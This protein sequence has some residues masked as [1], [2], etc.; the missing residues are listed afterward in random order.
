MLAFRSF[1]DLTV[2]TR[3]VLA[4][5]IP[6]T[7]LLGFN[8]AQLAGQRREVIGM[9]Q[10]ERQAALAVAVSNLIHELQRER[11]ASTLFVGSK[12]TKFGERLK[13]QRSLTGAKRAIFDSALN[14]S[15]NSS[16]DLRQLIADAQSRLGNLDRMRAEIDALSIDTGETA[17]YYT[18]TIGALLSAIEYMAVLSSNAEITNRI[19]AYTTFSRPRNARAIS[20]RSAPEAL[21]LGNSH[22]LCTGASSR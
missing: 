18:D 2:R 9:A 19:A 15:S 3:I 6:V 7:A 17:K 8:A 12:G 20:A 16:Q 1:R 4:L 11:G 14:K 21:R 10:V 5:I 22:R 13:E